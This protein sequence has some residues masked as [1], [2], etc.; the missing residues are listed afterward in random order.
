MEA[1]GVFQGYEMV[2]FDPNELITR[3][4]AVITAVRLI[5][6]ESE[7]QQSN[8]KLNFTETGFWLGNRL[9][10]GGYGKRSFQFSGKR[11]AAY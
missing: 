2:H 10:S 5:G 8:V 6:L 7:A 4:Q 3:H 9:C 1:S 11:T